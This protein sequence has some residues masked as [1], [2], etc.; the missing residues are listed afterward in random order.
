[1]FKFGDEVEFIFNDEIK[2]GTITYDTG[3]N[4]FTITNDDGRFFV[5]GADI[6][7]V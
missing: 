1:M 6:Q 5:P 2:H 7:K 3:K 4:W